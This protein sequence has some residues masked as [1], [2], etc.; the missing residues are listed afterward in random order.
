LRS[1]LT[2]LEHSEKDRKVTILNFSHPL[3][4]EHLTQ[5]EELTGQ[6]IECVKDVPTQVDP[7]RRL[8]EQIVELADRAG[9][10]PQE[11]QTTPLVVNLPGYAPAAAALLA[12]L[13]GRLGHFPTILWMQPLTTAVPTRYQAAEVVNLQAVRDEARRRR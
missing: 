8:D 10:T 3:T 1:K 12:E 7:S 6:A 13:H 4:S 2:G 9:L 5:V 11:W